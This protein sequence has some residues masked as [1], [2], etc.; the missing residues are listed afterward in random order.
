MQIGKVTV[1]V[2]VN[3][4]EEC[5]RFY[6]EVLSLPVRWS[7]TS[8]VLVRV[9]I[10]TQRVGGERLHLLDQQPLGE[11]PPQGRGRGRR[12]KPGHRPAGP[13]VRP[14]EAVP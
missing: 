9:G 12:L 13:P 1:P 10:I 14:S 5:R 11:R 6:A 4:L 3:D 8:G 2:T 7:T